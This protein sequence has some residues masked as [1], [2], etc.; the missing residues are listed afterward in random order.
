MKFVIKPPMIV[1]LL[2]FFMSCTHS[3]AVSVTE[4]TSSSSQ[5]IELAQQALSKQLQSDYHRIVLQPISKPLPMPASRKKLTINTHPIYPVS[6]RIG[7]WITQGKTR[8]VVW[9]QVQAFKQVFVAKHA[10]AYNTLIHQNDLKSV[11]RDIAGLNRNPLVKLPKHAWLSAH[12]LANQILLD[13]QIKIAPLV[14]QGQN[15]RVS[16][17][18]GQIRIVMDAIALNNGYLG[19]TIAVK[20]PLNHQTFRAR[21]IAANQA[22]V[23]G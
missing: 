23:I 10:M 18:S 16:A 9:F 17:H 6:K 14:Q 22:E 19:D 2:L 5:L 20:N 4:K 1:V 12:L 7:V 3:F 11:E 8:R 13:N 21:V 15:V